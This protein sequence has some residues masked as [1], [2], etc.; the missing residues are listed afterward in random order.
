MS[1]NFHDLDKIKRHLRMADLKLSMENL[2]ECKAEIESAV[3]IIDMLEKANGKHDETPKPSRKRRQAT[4][5]E[6]EEILR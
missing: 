3:S 2:K 4:Q 5:S 1:K 6:S